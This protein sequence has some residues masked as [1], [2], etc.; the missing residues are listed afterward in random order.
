MIGDSIMFVFVMRSINILPMKNE[1]R[2][3]LTF[4]V[5]RIAWVRAH[6]VDESFARVPGIIIYQVGR[7]D[8]VTVT[9]SSG[10]EG[11]CAAVFEEVVAGDASSG[12]VTGEDDGVTHRRFSNTCCQG[13]RERLVCRRDIE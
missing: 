9:Y 7:G 5:Q 11:C 12:A 8:G 3:V 10:K 6:R 13:W 1:T 2:N 4:Q